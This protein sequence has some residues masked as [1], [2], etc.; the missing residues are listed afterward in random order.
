MRAMHEQRRQRAKDY[1]ERT[2][3]TGVT[4]F[5]EYTQAAVELSRL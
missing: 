1:L 3:A 4:Y 2:L 5:Y